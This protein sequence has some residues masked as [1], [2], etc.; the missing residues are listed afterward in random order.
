MRN[1]PLVLLILVLASCVSAGEPEQVPVFSDYAPMRAHV[2]YLFGEQKFA[3]ARSVL[4]A[5]LAVFPDHLE[6]NAFNLACMHVMLKEYE[7]A[8]QV[9]NQAGDQGI[10]FGKFNIQT[11]L[12]APLFDRP[13]FLEFLARNDAM[14][15]AA[16]P[17]RVVVDIAL[18]T[19][20]DPDRKYPLFLAMHG[21][22][23]TNEE[24]KIFWHSP[25]LARE[26]V[27]AY[28]QSS[29][30]SNMRGFSWYVPAD[31]RADIMEAYEQVSA[32]YSIDPDRI[33]ISGYS[34]GAIATLCMAFDSSLSVRGYVCLG[35]PIPPQIMTE[36]NIAKAVQRGLRGAFIIGE[37]DQFLP[38]VKTIAAT[39]DSLGH[40][41]TML[42]LENEGH[43]YP[44]GLPA[45]IDQA[46]AKILD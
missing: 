46:L 37:H 42:V 35:P 45:L 39:F 8:V 27:L 32:A 23:G 40:Q 36:Q 38:E 31:I 19:G 5:H 29:I 22:D 17:G 6:A 24:F 25:R 15:E 41:N 20:Y 26:F 34:A 2:G 10:W 9:L 11:E 7:E 13:A 18:P 14:R 30:P 44:A 43:A 16:T 3:E 1:C 21:G 12:L 33:Y 4:S 28:V